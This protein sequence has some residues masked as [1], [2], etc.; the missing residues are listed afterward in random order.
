MQYVMGAMV[1]VQRH[2]AAQRYG[3]TQTHGAYCDNNGVTP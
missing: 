3:E 2:E 1:G